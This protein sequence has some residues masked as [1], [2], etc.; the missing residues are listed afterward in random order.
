MNEFVTTA[1]I[2][3]IFQCSRAKANAYKRM[4]HE[5]TISRGINVLN[6]RTCLKSILIELFITGKRGGK[7]LC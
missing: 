1:D 3:Q 7:K 5:E 6:N 2:M 4:V